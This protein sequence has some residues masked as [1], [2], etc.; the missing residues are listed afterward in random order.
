[1][2]EFLSTGGRII[3]LIVISP[4]ICYNGSTEPSVQKGDVL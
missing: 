2:P 1:M 3:F 4:R